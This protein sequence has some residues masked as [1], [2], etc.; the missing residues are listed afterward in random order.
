MQQPL[1]AHIIF[2]EDKKQ[3]LL[4]SLTKHNL[5]ASDRERIERQLEMAAAAVESYRRA[6]ELEYALRSGPSKV[7][8]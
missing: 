6:Y 2:L 8:P 1:Q 4:S 5:S 7:N 3:E